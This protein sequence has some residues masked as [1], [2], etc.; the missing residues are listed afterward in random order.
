MEKKKV[1]VIGET[2]KD[3]FVYG[4]CDRLNPEAPSPIFKIVGTSENLGMAAN[5]AANLE[6]IGMEVH[7]LTNH[8]H[9]TKKR[10]V[11]E[12]SN[13]ILLRIDDDDDIEIESLTLEDFYEFNLD[14]FDAVVISDYNK[15]LLTE[16]FIERVSI[17][18]EG[19]I[20]LFM[21]TK[22]PLDEWAIH[23]K[24]IKINEKE[25][26]NPLNNTYLMAGKTMLDK[27]VVTLGKNGCRYQGKEHKYG[28]VEMI[29]VAGAGDTFLAGLV[30]GVLHVGDKHMNY[31]FEL[32][33]MLAGDVVTK[34]GV[35]LP[36]PDLIT[37]FYRT[38]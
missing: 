3:V 7:L 34:R 33:N 21:D 18:C 23:C 29:D 27:M 12:N 11:D 36:N 9:I 16:E 24:F 38:L 35:A 31:V 22:K 1:L 37:K 13:H 15:G 26:N 25:F 2:C 32:A 6:E 19:K 10:F 17:L 28:K 5:V 20:P 4:K 8:E 14:D 30:Y